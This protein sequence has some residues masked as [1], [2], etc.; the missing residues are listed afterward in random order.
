MLIPQKR[1]QIFKFSS[2][3]GFEFELVER[4]PDVNPIKFGFDIPL[5]VLPS[6]KM[7]FHIN[8]AL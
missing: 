6:S 3:V 2:V 7:H 5:V 4:H 1:E 8:A